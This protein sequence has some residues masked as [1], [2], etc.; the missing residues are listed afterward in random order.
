MRAGGRI[1]AEIDAW[2]DVVEAS[3][4]L[5]RLLAEAAAFAS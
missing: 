4:D 1:E 5:D 3:L 2:A